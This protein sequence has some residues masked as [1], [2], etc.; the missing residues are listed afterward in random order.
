LLSFYRVV[1]ERGA[2]DLTDGLRKVLRVPPVSLAN[3]LTS[4][5]VVVR[6]GR[7][8]GARRVRTGVVLLVMML[9]V[10]ACGSSYPRTEVFRS[11]NPLTSDLYIRITGPGGAVGYV[12]QRFRNSRLFDSYSFRHAPNE[13]VFLPPRIRDRKLCAATHIIRRGDAPQLQKWRGRTL[14]ISVY[15][16]KSSAIF[17][18]VLGSVLYLGES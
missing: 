10:A 12:G 5:A 17:C 16:K 1:V 2:F 14:A 6:Q 3:A 18:A 15:G 9:S 11:T 7:L 4:D 13:G 8:P